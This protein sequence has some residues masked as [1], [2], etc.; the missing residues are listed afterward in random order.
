MLDNID[1]NLGQVSSSET[2][3]PAASRLAAQRCLPESGVASVAAKA[4]PGA[5]QP[6]VVSD[7]EE[8]VHT[9]TQRHNPLGEAA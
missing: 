8:S 3:Q 2:A 7:H 4:A 6:L 9:Q 5:P 1:P